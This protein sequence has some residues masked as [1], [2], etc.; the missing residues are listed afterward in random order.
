[1][2]RDWYTAEE[3]IRHLRPARCLSGGVHVGV[4]GKGTG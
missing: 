4:Y 1:M 3:I 2:A